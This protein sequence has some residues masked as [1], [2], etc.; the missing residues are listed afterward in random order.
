MS[1]K[2]SIRGIDAR[3][4]IACDVC[5]EPIKARDKANARYPLYSDSGRQEPTYVE[6]KRCTIAFDKR[7]PLPAGAWH[8]GWADLKLTV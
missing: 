7:F 5:G 2:I 1:L 3:A 6:H 8:W 4:S